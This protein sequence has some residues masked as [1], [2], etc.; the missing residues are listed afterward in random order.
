MGW[1]VREVL[2]R[3]AFGRVERLE[4]ES[5][6]SL[7][8][9]VACGG[10]MPGSGL[11]A[12][13][14]Q[15]RERAALIA[16]E[17]VQGV[18]R[19]VEEES[20]LRAVAAGEPPPRLVELSLREWVV[21]APLHRAEL[22]PADFFDHLDRLVESLHARGV[23]HNDLHKEMNVIVGCDGFPWLIDF[24]LASLHPG[25]GRS[26]RARVRDDLRHVQKHRRR[27][28]R[29][30][31]G[32]KGARIA[33]G[34]GHGLERRGLAR[35]WRRTGKPLYNGITRGILRTSDGEERRPSSGPWPSWSE[36]LG[37]RPA[38]D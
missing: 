29:D 35:V 9:R 26:F 34:R 18:P 19:V 14:L 2:K 11:V 3:D 31:R 21:G 37:E 24:Q 27:Y 28:L 36:A 17:G 23:C 8:R 38:R 16:L 15:R 5:G 20:A 12:R 4:D 32:P 10:G 1:Q 33:A 13:Y 6:A 30:G 22:L 25:R 7:L